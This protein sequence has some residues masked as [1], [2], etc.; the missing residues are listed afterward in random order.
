VRRGLAV[1]LVLVLLGVWAFVLRGDGGPARQAPGTEAGPVTP[2]TA[3]PG[4][5]PP[6]EP[7]RTL[8]PGFEEIAITVR[9]DGGDPLFWCLLAAL[10]AG[11]RARGLMGVTDLQGYAGMVFLYET[12][13]TNAFYMRNTPTPL[14]IAWVA[15]DGRVVTIRD[16][17]PCEDR[18]GC[19]V[20]APG[21]PYRYALEV[22]QD[23]L[24]DLGITEDATVTVGGTCAPA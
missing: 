6:G 21:G 14:S 24:P 10:T 20:Y 19:P 17:A 3:P 9:P 11:Q 22:F 16:M 1:A 5:V 23:D 13:V 12:D 18:E 4:F 2:P 8:L 7:G 15:V